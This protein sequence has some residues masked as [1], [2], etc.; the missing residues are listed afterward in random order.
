MGG[1]LE[2]NVVKAGHN[3]CHHCNRDKLTNKPLSL[4]ELR[5]MSDQLSKITLGRL[6]EDSIKA[7]DMGWKHWMSFCSRFRKPIFLKCETHDEAAA[8]AAQAQLFMTYETAC[9]DIKAASV[10]QKLWAVGVRHKATFRADPMS[11]NAM[12]KA[13]IADAVALDT[14]SEQKIPI[15]NTTLAFLKSA[16]D[17]HSRS[18]STLWTG[19]RFAIA[20][21]CRISEWA[22]N[23]KYSVKWKHISFFTTNTVKLVQFRQFTARDRIWC[24]SIVHVV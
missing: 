15:T 2:S 11:G 13:V 24:I 19:V 1:E 21:L 14:P 8:A 4:L 23:D 12:V 3:V 10:A 6:D 5:L 7:E 20:F 9:F 22:W 16:L 17:T 18:G